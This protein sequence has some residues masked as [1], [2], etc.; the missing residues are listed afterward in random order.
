MLP[1]FR[2]LA[3]DTINEQLQKVGLPQA[4]IFEA[5]RLALCKFQ[6]KY[7]E[8]LLASLASIVTAIIGKLF[9]CS[10]LFHQN[11]HNRKV[12]QDAAV[13]RSKSFAGLP[14]QNRP[15]TTANRPPPKPPSQAK[16]PQ[17]FNSWINSQLQAHA[18]AKPTVTVPVQSRTQPDA[19]ASHSL[20]TIS[21]TSN[22]F[23]LNGM[24]IPI[25]FQ[26]RALLACDDVFHQPQGRAIER[27]QPSGSV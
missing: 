12:L 14:I 19:A 16:S 3:P 2:N 17:P 22:N 25:A 26:Q 15:T 18:Q 23:F 9:V 24:V 6:R 1:A 4:E 5:L 7:Q 10:C 8:S 13:Q 21:L 11:K 20:L 27:Y